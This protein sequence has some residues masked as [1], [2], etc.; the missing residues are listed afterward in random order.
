[1][2]FPIAHVS[3]NCVVLFWL[4]VTKRSRSFAYTK[5]PI[6]DGR[7][8]RD[9]SYS[10]TDT[11]PG[12]TVIVIKITLYTFGAD[13]GSR[14]LVVFFSFF[15]F[16]LLIS[17]MLFQVSFNCTITA[18]STSKKKPDSG[19]LSFDTTWLHKYACSTYIR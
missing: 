7:Y 9:T 16:R 6:K 19:T 2:R 5:P 1:M 15:L 12:Y 8:T 17:F 14:F 3:Y 18:F 10:L 4:Y 11:I 13:D